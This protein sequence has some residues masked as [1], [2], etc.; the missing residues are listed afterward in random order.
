MTATALDKINIVDLVSIF[1]G[2]VLSVYIIDYFKRAHNVYEGMYNQ[3]DSVAYPIPAM[4][5]LQKTKN[6]DT[7]GKV[8]I[9]ERSRT[10]PVNG[11]WG[12]HDFRLIDKALTPGETSA[13]FNRETKYHP[14]M[15]LQ[16][17]EIRKRSKEHMYTA[18][19]HH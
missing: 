18:R 7:R 17:D 1:V 2:G 5:K 19:L 14:W 3:P 11:Y 13:L 16:R 4:M 8:N 10:Q 9:T 12:G 15:S 6:I